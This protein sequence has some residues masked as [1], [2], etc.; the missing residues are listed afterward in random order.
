[1]IVTVTSSPLTYGDPNINTIYDNLGTRTLIGSDYGDIETGFPSPT[2]FFY[3]RHD[4]TEP[5]YSCGFYIKA[6]GSN[7]GGYVSTADTSFFPYNPNFFRNG[8]IDPVTLIPNTSTDDYELLRI[9][10]QN[11]Q[12]MGVRLNFDRTND[13]ILENSL[14]YNNIGLSFNPLPLSI[15]SMDYSLTS[16]PQ[17]EG[18][19]YPAPLDDTKRGKF[20]DEARVGVSIKLPVEVTGSGIVQFGVAMKYRYTQ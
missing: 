18:T 3:F 4:G 14:G 9:S 16:S 17:I 7:W 10:A 1:M 19:I 15:N 2:K 12:E 5:I 20:G 11:N 6:I 13:L 8:G